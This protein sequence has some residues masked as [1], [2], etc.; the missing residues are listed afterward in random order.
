MSNL[1]TLQTINEIINKIKYK[2]PKYRAKCTR[3]GKMRKR[4]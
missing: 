2:G 4:G 3:S 1:D